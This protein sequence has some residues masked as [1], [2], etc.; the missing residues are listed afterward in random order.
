MSTL[1]R[2]A[3]NA[4]SSEAISKMKMA[5][6]KEELRERELPVTGT[7]SDLVARLCESCGVEPVRGAVRC[8]AGGR[9]RRWAS[10]VRR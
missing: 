10:R 1:K 9:G 5:E 3:P 6:L 2:A 7:R 4:L 8:V